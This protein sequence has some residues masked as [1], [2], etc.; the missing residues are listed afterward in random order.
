MRDAIKSKTRRKK[1]KKTILALVVALIMCFSLTACGGG[2]GDTMSSKYMTVDAVCVADN[3][4]D[5]EG[6]GLELVYLFYTVS[7]DDS[8]LSVTSASTDLTVDGTNTYSSERVIGAADYA[9]S[10]YFSDYYEDVNTGTELKVVETFKIPAADLEAGK[11]ITL[12]NSNIPEIGDIS[13]STD[14]IQHFDSEEA[15]AEA[16]D[17]DGYAAEVELRADADADTAAQVKDLVNGYYWTFYVNYT[18]YEMEFWAPNNFEVRTSLGV[19]NSG[20]YTVQNGYL[21]C[22]YPSND[23]TVMVPYELVDGDVELDCVAAFDVN[24]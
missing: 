21:F 11:T 9:S 22:T 4:A 3:Y 8:N 19:T 1:M 14:V 23:Y 6:E 13:I 15:V 5:E 10:Y 17:P 24:E 18:T 12:E 2:G 16:V 7:T 20:T